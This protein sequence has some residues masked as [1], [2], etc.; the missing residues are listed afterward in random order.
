MSRSTET[1]LR[2]RYAETD[3]MGVVY[4]SNYLVWMEIGRTDF[5]LHSGFRY[6]DMEAEDG[7]MI[8]VAEARCR[9]RRPARYDDRILIRTSLTSLKRRILTFS[10]DIRNADT[11]E[12]LATGATVHVAVGADGAQ[13]SIPSRQFDLL[14]TRAE[15][16]R[17]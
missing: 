2:V 16:P 1:T 12:Q 15:A 17:E 5:C 10:Y 7:V 14:S 13:R 4:Y 8:A 6:R 11:G 9:Y 3:Q